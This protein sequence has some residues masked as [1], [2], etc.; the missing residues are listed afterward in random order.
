MTPVYY[1]KLAAVW[2]R[3][4]ELEPPYSR[5]RPGLLKRAAQCMELAS[6]LEAQQRGRIA[7]K[8]DD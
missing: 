7:A 2:L 3:L 8:E 4:A 5:E 1:Y 6:K